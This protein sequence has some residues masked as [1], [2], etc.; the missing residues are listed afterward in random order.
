[1][2]ISSTKILGNGQQ[3]LDIAL[4]QFRPGAIRR[5][6]RMLHKCLHVTYTNYEQLLAGERWDPHLLDSAERWLQDLGSTVLQ[7]V[8][9]HPR[10]RADLSGSDSRTDRRC[11]IV[12][13]NWLKRLTISGKWLR[14]SPAP[15][16]KT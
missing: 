13:L 16:S 3:W 8:L 9:D 11:A 7:K 2:E 5:F 10:A 12:L 6:C 15:F 1:M 4:D 14:A